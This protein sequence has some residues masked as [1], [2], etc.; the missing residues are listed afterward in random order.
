MVH[1]LTIGEIQ[2]A[3]RRR[4]KLAKRCLKNECKKLSKKGKSSKKRRTSGSD[5]KV[6]DPP[7]HSE[8]DCE[9]S[10]PDTMSCCLSQW[11]SSSQLAVN[12]GK[13]V[14]VFL[15]EN[16]DPSVIVK[17]VITKFLTTKVK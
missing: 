9:I 13:V 2:S 8:S 16:N 4:Y 5:V 15:D 17:Q 7:K 14:P 3:D 11:S 10:D 6:A 12:D 1:P